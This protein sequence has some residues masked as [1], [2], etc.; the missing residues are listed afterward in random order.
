VFCEARIVKFGD[1]RIV[2]KSD[3][4]ARLGINSIQY[5][6]Y[7]ESDGEYRRLPL[8]W[9]AVVLTLGT[10]SRWRSGGDEWKVFP[11]AAIRGHAGCWTE[12]ADQPG[13]GCEYMTALIE[14]WAFEALTGTS[15]GEVAGRVVDVT[16]IRPLWNRFRLDMILQATDPGAKLR[17]FADA[18]MPQRDIV[19]DTRIKRFASACRE[20]AG[21]IRVADAVES[22][23]ISTRQFRTVFAATLGLSPKAWARLERF[24]A[25]LHELHPR[26]SLSSP[27][28]LQCGYFDQSHAIKDFKAFTGATPGEYVRQKAEGDDRIFLLKTA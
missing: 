22:M 10:P 7:A 17:L 16:D 15:A 12:G 19:F 25:Y 20:Q 13:R 18:L 23:R 28:M 5:H 24:S 27:R 1:E 6:R 3:A 4:L 9:I 8:P 26:E 11:P 2:W 14:P 21:S